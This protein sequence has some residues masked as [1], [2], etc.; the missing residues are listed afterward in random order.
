MNTIIERIRRAEYGIVELEEHLSYFHDKYAMDLADF[1]DKEEIVFLSEYSMLNYVRGMSDL[2]RHQ[3]A[4]IAN[5]EAMLSRLD[6]CWDYYRELS[7]L[8]NKFFARARRAG[9]VEPIK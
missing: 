9:F 8:Q 4:G 5:T 2:V 7:R 3:L 6:A 1:S